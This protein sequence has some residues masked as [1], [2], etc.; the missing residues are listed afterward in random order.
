MSRPRVRAAATGTAAAV[1]VALVAGCSAGPGGRGQGNDASFVAGDGSTVV[2][3]AAD[4]APAVDLQGS[5]LDGKPWSLADR[6]G[7]VVV[8]NVWASWCPPCRAEAPALARTARRFAAKGVE[9]VGV[10][11]RDSATSGQ[12]YV[13]HFAIPYPNLVDTDGRLILA[14]RD[15]L[16]AAS[17]PTT[18]VIDQQGRVAARA[19]SEVD[20]SRLRGMIEPLLGQGPTS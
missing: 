4:R 8:V 2:V 17:I 20:E 15:S 7:K 10:D 6:R 13:D 18:L 9:F 16:P 19:L 5:T 12:G 1:A 14:F 11:T 3:A